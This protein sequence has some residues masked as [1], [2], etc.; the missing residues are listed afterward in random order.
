MQ[1]IPLT[2]EG[3]FMN[4][5]CCRLAQIAFFVALISFAGPNLQ[6]QSYVFGNASYSAPGLS[7][8]SPPPG[9]PGIVTAD[10]NGD[11]IPD[12][13]ILGTIPSGQS[14]SIFLGKPDGSFGPRV[15]YPVQASGFT[16]GDFNGD[17]KVDVVVVS[18][19]G[20]SIF[21]GNGDG[22]LQPPVSLNQNLG[23]G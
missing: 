19:T 1:T 8:I 6:A 23:S 16:V 12:V 21:F 9:N 3:D 18:S 14:L 2:L 17:G 20:T 7:S 15:D 10:F 11:G 13:A 5:I 22:T 4:A